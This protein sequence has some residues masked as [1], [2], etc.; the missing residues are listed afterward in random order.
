M[1]ISNM[2]SNIAIPVPGATFSD[3]LNLI[4][5]IQY[6]YVYPKEYI[7]QSGTCKYTRSVLNNTS[8]L[9]NKISVS[10]NEIST[11]LLQTV[12]KALVSPFT[13]VVKK[14]FKE[15]VFPEKLKYSQNFPMKKKYIEFVSQLHRWC[16]NVFKIV[17]CVF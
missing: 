10:W 15:G 7:V 6:E 3:K 14:S 13:L 9:K 1:I 4:K 5:Q 16:F 2:I 11:K 8:S 12:V 17:L